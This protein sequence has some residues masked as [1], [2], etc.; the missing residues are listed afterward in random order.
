M[1]TVNRNYFNNVFEMIKDL[2][3]T[4]LNSKKKK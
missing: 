4:L 1:S 2:I 3:Y